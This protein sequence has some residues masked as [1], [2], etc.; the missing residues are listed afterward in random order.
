M[1]PG[2]VSHANDG[3]CTNDPNKNVDRGVDKHPT[4]HAV[5]SLV[6]VVALSLYCF[7]E[8]TS[9]GL[10]RSVPGVFMLLVAL[11]CH[12]TVIGFSLGLQFV[13]SSYSTRKHYATAFVYSIVEPIGVA[14]GRLFERRQQ[15]ESSSLLFKFLLKSPF[16]EYPISPLWNRVLGVH[17]RL[18]KST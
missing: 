12:D 6:L 16:E 14:I 8:G 1:D 10:Q 18:N 2:C 11:L 13:K 4:Q 3:C 9:L 17:L 7:F 15:F 5:R